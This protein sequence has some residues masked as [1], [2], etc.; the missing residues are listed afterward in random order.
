M[1]E[2]A[3]MRV[4]NT[5]RPY[6]SVLGQSSNCVPSAESTLSHPVNELIVVTRQERGSEHSIKYLAETFIDSSTEIK[7]ARTIVWRYLVKRL[8]Y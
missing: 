6:Q 8:S 4:L 2:N 5:W 7:M 3:I 1:A